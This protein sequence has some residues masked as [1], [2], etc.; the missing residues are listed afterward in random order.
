VINALSGA[1]TARRVS[2]LLADTRGVN[3]RGLSGWVDRVYR[4]K[5]KLQ[6]G[7]FANVDVGMVS[8]DMSDI[9]K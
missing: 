5:A 1:I 6:V 4:A 3:V 8:L 7:Q 9:S 2:N